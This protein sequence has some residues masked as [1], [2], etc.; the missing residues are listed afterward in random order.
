MKQEFSYKM[1]MTGIIA[2]C[3]MLLIMQ[4]LSC[5]KTPDPDLVLIQQTVPEFTEEQYYAVRATSN[6]VYTVNDLLRFLSQ[7]GTATIDVIPAFNNYYQD[8]GT[9]GSNLGQL[10][11]ASGVLFINNN[12]TLLTDTIGYTFDWYI[13]NVLQCSE[14]NP[15]L[16][17]LDENLI[18]D[19]VVELRLDITTPQ[20]AKY[21]RTQ[22][23]YIDY[24]YISNCTCDTCPGLSQV[25]YT[26]YPN[27]P[28]YFYQI[29]C[30][31]FDFD[32][33]QLVDINDLLQFLSAYGG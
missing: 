9:G 31:E 27:V 1:V 5:Q 22:W 18:C 15:K 23:S 7:Y 33:N 24:N 19:G 32:C 20:G 13:N 25:F 14:A 6:T 28:L 4:A 26:F 8:I 12:G 17:D 2:I 3:T 30:A 11:K 21:T 29:K 10:S 16:W